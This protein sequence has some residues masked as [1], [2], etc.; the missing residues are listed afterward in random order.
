LEEFIV[1][2]I[3]FNM[4]TKK[5]IKGR[6]WLNGF[7]G[8]EVLHKVELYSIHRVMHHSSNIQ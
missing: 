7:E 3:L 1:L 4:V 6:K 2:E 5:E 8:F